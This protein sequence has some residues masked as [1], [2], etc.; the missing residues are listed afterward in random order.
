[1]WKTCFACFK[2][3]WGVHLF[4]L[5]KA[6]DTV[7]GIAMAG[8]ALNF[9]KTL[10][11]EEVIDWNCNVTDCYFHCWGWMRIKNPQQF[12]IFKE[13]TLL[14]K[15]KIKNSYLLKLLTHCSLFCLWILH[16][17]KNSHSLSAVV[18]QVLIK[19]QKQILKNLV[20]WGRNERNVRHSHKASA[21]LWFYTADASL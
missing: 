4:I 19:G 15:I 21:I 7:L 5:H 9:E 16:V 17:W 18:P 11:L 2:L 14:D 1:M 13:Y 8:E 3:L 12:N 20:E 6:Q 10:D